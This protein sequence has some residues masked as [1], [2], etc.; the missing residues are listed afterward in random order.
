M[1]LFV[2]YR[3]T[4]RIVRFF[5]WRV[6]VFT[7]LVKRFTCLVKTFTRHVKNDWFR[8]AAVLPDANHSF[9]EVW[10]ALEGL[11]VLAYDVADQEV[12]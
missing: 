6:K 11:A 12:G 3:K 1:R 2:I 4:C 7:C 5:T 8:Q 10:Q 9:Y